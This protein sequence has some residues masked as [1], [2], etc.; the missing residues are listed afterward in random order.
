MPTYLDHHNPP[1]GISPEA[2]EKMAADT[3]AGKVDQ[4][5]VKLLNAFLRQDVVWC[6]TEAPSADVAHQPHEAN[7]GLNMSDGDVIEVQ[8]LV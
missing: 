6:L 2:L 1:Q 7:Y 3:K 8:M 4:F 5:G